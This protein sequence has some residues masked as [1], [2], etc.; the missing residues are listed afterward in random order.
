MGLTCPEHQIVK[1][2]GRGIHQGRRRKLKDINQKVTIIYYLCILILIT[3]ANFTFSWIYLNFHIGNKK[4]SKTRYN[5][6]QRQYSSN[7]VE[8][9]QNTRG[10]SRS[11]RPQFAKDPSQ[12]ETSS[13]H[14][15]NFALSSNWD[16]KNPEEF[17]KLRYSLASNTGKP[18]RPN[19]AK[20]KDDN[21]L[22][23]IQNDYSS[24][25]DYK[26][27]NQ[28][29]AYNFDK[30]SFLD[31]F[32]SKDGWSRQPHND[33]LKYNQQELKKNKIYES[34]KSSHR[35]SRKRS[36]SR[37]RTNESHKY[38]YSS[39]SK[40]ANRSRS[41]K[42]SSKPRDKS[43]DKHSDKHMQKTKSSNNLGPNN[44][45][46]FH[47]TASLKFNNIL[48]DMGA[49]WGPS[50]S[51]TFLNY[52]DKV[53]SRDMNIIKSSR[54]PINYSNQSSKCPNQDTSSKQ[55]ESSGLK[56]NEIFMMN[57][58]SSHH[59]YLDMVA[60]QKPVSREHKRALLSSKYTSGDTSNS[61]I[62]TSFKGK[63]TVISISSITHGGPK[64]HKKG[65][66]KTAEKKVEDPAIPFPQSQKHHSSKFNP[67]NIDYTATK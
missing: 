65:S 19:S 57:A 20:R 3:N 43:N 28:V 27:S 31:Q 56:P 10:S 60:N 54:Q 52:S 7:N 46:Y 45:A 58:N 50:Q 40:N 17:H 63:N 25:H 23:A 62:D 67:K 6:Y 12:K 55:K 38:K 30:N 41:N 22:N 1:D 44:K 42:P 59:N 34:R 11:S 15:S 32:G 29:K 8:E 33:E 18:K 21:P 64:N 13:K 9:K 39:G 14:T 49:H 5:L 4:S 51:T 66:K 53:K 24:K 35:E 61:N 47:N 36:S 16:Y 26:V 48:K 2:M 37:D